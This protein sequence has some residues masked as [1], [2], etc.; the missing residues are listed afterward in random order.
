[1]AR[2][3][4][5]PDLSQFRPPGFSLP[6]YREMTREWGAREW[7]EAL[8]KRHKALEALDDYATADRGLDGSY[9]RGSRERTLDDLAYF[10]PSLFPVP[11]G[12]LIQR[13][14][15]PNPYL[16]DAG[17]LVRDLSVARS[18]HLY[19]NMTNSKPFVKTHE[20]CIDPEDYFGF[21]GLA[22]QLS[23]IHPSEWE[24]PVERFFGTSRTG[25][26]EDHDTSVLEVSLLAPNK[27]IVAA[28]ERWLATTRQTRGIP[29]P[30]Q[31]VTD[32]LV[33][34]STNY[35]SWQRNGVLPFLDLY[36]WNRWHNPPPCPGLWSDRGD[37][38]FYEGKTWTLAN[39]TWMSLLETDRDKAFRRDTVNAGLKLLEPEA[40]RLLAALARKERLTQ[41]EPNGPGQKSA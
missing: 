40:M 8:W 29:E 13:S 24:T 3:N 4:P 17:V 14:Y 36:L 19:Q 27:E 15:Y 28:F 32:K 22:E 26:D 38:F 16:F 39:Q 34:T 21:P 23:V 10:L 35:G 33:F 30:E 20:F 12:G 18:L 7:Y 1:M 41:P 25:F 5:D 2:G 37:R 9:L 31:E 11:P 6:A